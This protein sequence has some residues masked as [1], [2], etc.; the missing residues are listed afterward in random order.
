MV[1]LYL[2][3]PDGEVKD[4]LATLRGQLPLRASGWP[5]SLVDAFTEAI[6]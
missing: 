6:T 4:S 5:C 2:A 3:V 1:N